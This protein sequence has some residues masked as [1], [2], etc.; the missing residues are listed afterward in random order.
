MV[1]DTEA[2]ALVSH[3]REQSRFGIPLT[4]LKRLT[5]RIAVV[6]LIGWI[7]AGFIGLRVQHWTLARLLADTASFLATLWLLSKLRHQR[8]LGTGTQDYVFPS[9]MRTLVK[10]D[11]IYHLGF[12]GHGLF[13]V[14]MSL[15][16]HEDLPDCT[17]LLLCMYPALAASLL[18]RCH[19]AVY[20]VCLAVQSRSLLEVLRISLDGAVI[21]GLCLGCPD[22]I[23]HLLFDKVHSKAMCRSQIPGPF[24]F[25]VGIVALVLNLVASGAVLARAHVTEA[26][27]SRDSLRRLALFPIS[28][29]LLEVCSPWLGYI[30]ESL[31]GLW[32]VGMYWL[33][34]RSA[35]VREATV[36]DR[37][38]RY[39]SGDML[40]SREGAGEGSASSNGSPQ[41]EDANASDGRGEGAKRLEAIAREHAA[42]EATIPALPG[43]SE[44][45]GRSARA[46]VQRRVSAVERELQ[47]FQDLQAPQSPVHFQATAQVV[48]SSSEDHR[49][50]LMMEKA[51]SK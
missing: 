27:D 32:F 33:L 35:R 23:S 25:I 39:S 36:P 14:V 12:A 37:I 15:I 2:D 21:A 28:F 45:E 41:H 29:F 1:A 47:T 31:S 7:V 22:V 5:S 4:R 42:L 8:L 44:D 34:A 10:V 13:V 19:I 26:V 9:Q 16:L 30:P 24:L 6:I 20:N 43:N 17:L 49:A 51:L 11:C 50:P 46:F 3:F 38:A 40:L 18:M 48:D